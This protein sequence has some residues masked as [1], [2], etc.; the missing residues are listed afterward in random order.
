MV[1]FE[2]TAHTEK[3]IEELRLHHGLPDASM[4]ITRAIALLLAAK[5]LEHPDGSFMVLKPDG[6]I[7]KI[8]RSNASRVQ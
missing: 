1:K 5:H 6:G 4:V 2:L 7:V 3:T 8:R